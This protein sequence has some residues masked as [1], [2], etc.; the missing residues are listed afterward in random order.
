MNKAGNQ[1][2]QYFNGPCYMCWEWIIS[3]DM[4]I[5]DLLLDVMFNNACVNCVIEFP[6]CPGRYKAQVT[7]HWR[8]DVMLLET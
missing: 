5:V 4:Y 7:R 3:S 6:Y 8:D 1:F 2:V